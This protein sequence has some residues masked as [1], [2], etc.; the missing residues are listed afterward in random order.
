MH[1]SEL[2]YKLIAEQIFEYINQN[3]NDII[4]YTDNKKIKIM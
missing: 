2:G 1:P 4:R 3:K